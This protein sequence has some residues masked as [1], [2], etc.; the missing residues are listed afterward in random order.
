MAY[1]H[2]K[3]KSYPKIGSHVVKDRVSSC[4]VLSSNVGFPLF[5]F[6]DRHTCFIFHVFMEATKEGSLSFVVAKF[7][8]LLGFGF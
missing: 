1:K 8:G 5:A 7:D 6:C 4:F 2:S 3:S